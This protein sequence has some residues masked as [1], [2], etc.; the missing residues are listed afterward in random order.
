M[1]GRLHHLVIDCPD[2]QAL[3]RF[4]SQLLGLPVTYD[5]PN[6]VVVAESDTSS[7]IAFQ[8]VVNYRPPTWPDPDVPQ[9]M[10]WDVMVDD[11]DAAGAAATALGARSLWW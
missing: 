10:H 4:W 5:L 8:L 3:A 11:L 1:I 2:P 7:G 6:F 9:Q